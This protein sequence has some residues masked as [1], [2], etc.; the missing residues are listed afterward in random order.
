[1]TRCALLDHA[2]Q[3][4][5]QQIGMHV[6]GRPADYNAG[7]DNIV[8]SQARFLRIKLAEYFESASGRDEPVVLTIPKGTYLPRFEH[9]TEVVTAGPAPR[10]RASRSTGQ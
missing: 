10:G 8:R 6:F 7:D 2:E 9:R 5:E 4:T 3:V 1:M